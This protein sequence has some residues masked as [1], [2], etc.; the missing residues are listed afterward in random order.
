MKRYIL[1]IAA[2]LFM[3]TW[4]FPQSVD[5][6]YQ[7]STFIG[8]LAD[9]YASLVTGEFIYDEKGRLIMAKDTVVEPIQEAG[10]WEEIYYSYDESSNQGQ[11]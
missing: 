10:L 3:T 5:S 8:Y 2:L 1:T 7:P 6:F 11:N 9:D 4:T